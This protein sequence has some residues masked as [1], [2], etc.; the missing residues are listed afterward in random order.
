MVP[1]LL[2]MGLLVS[3]FAQAQPVSS[4]APISRDGPATEKVPHHVKPGSVRMS[5]LINPVC[6]TTWSNDL[7][8]HTDELEIL[9]YPFAE[10]ATIRDPQGL[11]AHVVRD[12]YDSRSLPKQDVNLFR[13]ADG[14][15]EGKL[16]LVGLETRY[17]AYWFE[18]TATHQTDKNH[19]DYFDVFFCNFDGTR[20]AQSVAA[21]ARSYIGSMRAL[22]V[23]RPVDYKRA[24][25]ILEAMSSPDPNAY[26]EL[27]DLWDYKLRV[28]GDTPEGHAKITAELEQFIDRYQSNE[29]ALMATSNFVAGHQSW[30][31]DALK[32]KLWATMEKLDP[33]YNAR[34]YAM[35][36]RAHEKRGEEKREE[37]REIIAKYPDNPQTEWAV[38]TLFME[39][40]DL[41][42]R[43]Q[44]YPK[45]KSYRPADPGSRL[46]MARAY[47]E[48]NTKLP[49]A[50][51]ILDEANETIEAGHSRRGIQE[52]TGSTIHF[53]D[54]SYR[55]LHGQVV[56]LRSELLLRT[57]HAKEGLALLEPLK[58]T[59]GQSST[60]YLL[61]EELEATGEAKGAL[62]AYLQA[63]IRPSKDDQEHNETL[64]RFWKAHHL[65]TQKQ[66]DAKI[67]AAVEERYAQENYV[68][69]LIAGGGP[70]FDLVALDGKH[71]TS[72]SLRG[73][74][75][76]LTFWAPWCAPCVLELGPMQEY[77][78]RHPEIAV[79]AA[80][81]P[82][83]ADETVTHALRQRKVEHLT[84]AKA[85]EDATA[86]FGV[87]GVPHTFVLDETGTIRV[88]HPGGLMDLEKHLDAD[89][90]AIDESKGK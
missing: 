28:Y 63:V 39:T 16:S 76:V 33:S 35:V 80:V 15:W 25:E 6:P 19:G 1:F 26:N 43:E 71:V 22:G 42:E 78:R 70:E 64:A 7:Y 14:V 49:E 8:P 3:L 81:V 59:M 62:D 57:G 32:E 48:A 58:P 68:P 12:A 31:P 41:K 34:V 45:L 90:K 36:R 27:E 29:S 83:N 4:Q 2:S 40:K 44:L 84:V 72:A 46:T 88:E 37:L 56:V 65:G 85:T 23:E 53:S 89:M 17:A 87:R 20:S 79:I 51:A 77:Q 75:A 52:S 47:I 38:M 11:T 30:L 54:D 5:S 67:T 21:K 13:R 55:M 66:L 86:A 9:Y 82:G 74:K 60:F 73:K 10:R 18:D 24:V 50:G 61:G 69:K